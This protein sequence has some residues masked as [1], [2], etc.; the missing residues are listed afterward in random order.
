MSLNLG[1]EY[2]GQFLAHYASQYY[3]P[4]K[5]H[6]YYLQNRELAGRQSTADL[7]VKYATKSKRGDKTV[8]KVNQAASERKKEAWAYAKNQ[9][10]E[11]QK[12]E[13]K[14]AAEHRKQVVKKAQQTA[15]KR[16]KEIAAGLKNLMELITGAKKSESEQI[17]EDENSALAKLDE[18]RAAK[19]R[20]IRDDASRQIDAIPPVPDGVRGPQRERLLDARAKKI[21][22]IN[23]D[24]ARAIQGVSKETAAQREAISADFDAR[25]ST[26]SEDVQEVRTSERESATADRNQVAK[27][28]KATV[29][30]A[31]ADYETGKKRVIA[32]YEAKKQKEFDAIRTRV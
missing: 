21:A 15:T 27:Q 13:I 29:D 4:Q 23:G 17:D 1:E 26:L 24:S 31:R 18:E 11:A 5:A 9:L 6:E 25:R 22:R 8:M 30:K 28:L 7:T 14:A 20:K 10:S 16:R 12:A 3:D 32:A 2:V 19:S